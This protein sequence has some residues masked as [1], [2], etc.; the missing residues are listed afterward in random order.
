MNLKTIWGYLYSRWHLNDYSSVYMMFTVRWYFS[1][2]N[3]LKDEG[4]GNRRGYEVKGVLL[5]SKEQKLVT[6]AGTKGKTKKEQVWL[7]TAAPGRK[8]EGQMGRAWHS[9][10]NSPSMTVCTDQDDHI[11]SQQA[12]GP[13]LWLNLKVFLCLYIL[14]IDSWPKKITLGDRRMLQEH[15]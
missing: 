11:C 5:N 14:Q 12:S 9:C 4:C 10:V 3:D 1:C 15:N 7:I 2:Y 8:H 6:R 13:I